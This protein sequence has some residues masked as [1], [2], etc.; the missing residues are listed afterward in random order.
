MENTYYFYARVDENEQPI[1]SVGA[2]SR[3]QAA[4]FFSKLKCLELKE[5]LKI[6]AISR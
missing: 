6:Y 3:Y 2:P 1:Y 5:F 4:I